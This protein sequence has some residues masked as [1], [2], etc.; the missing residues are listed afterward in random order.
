M[1]LRAPSSG[2]QLAHTAPRLA[3]AANATSV[4]G[5]LGMY[6]TTRSPAPTPSRWSPARARATCSRNSPNVSS[7]E[8]RVWPWEVIATVS[9][10]S[11]PPIMCSAKLSRAPGNQRA[12]G[13]SSDASTA[14]YG[15]CALTSKKSQIDCPE[16]GQI[17][18]GPLLQILVACE[19]APALA[20]EPGEVA[21]DLARLADVGRRRPEDARRAHQRGPRRWP[22]PSEIARA[23][24]VTTGPKR[25]IS[26][27]AESIV[28]CT[29]RLSAATTSPDCER[30]G[31]A[32]ERS[33]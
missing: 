33:P 15:A 18:D 28:R 9:A 1:T 25:A 11:S 19:L 5:M 14:L 32:I 31:E 22:V 6:A 3:V 4:S 29:A 16:A 23:V 17:V 26:S 27:S 20:R 8:A 12:P 21:A 2:A 30:I 10:S 13:I 7:D 24:R